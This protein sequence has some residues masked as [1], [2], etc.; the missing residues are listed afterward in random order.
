LNYLYI[1]PLLGFV[2]FLTPCTWNA[3]LILRA[4]VKARGMRELLL[5]VCGRVF[6][7][8][9]V[10]LCLHLFSDLFS[11]TEEILKAIQRGTALVFIVSFP[12][13]KRTGFAPFDLSPQFLF[14]HLSMP[15]GLSLGL[16]VPYCAV[17]FFVLLI[18]YSLTFGD[19]FLFF[20]LYLL[21]NLLPTVVVAV[22]PGT[23]LKNLSRLVPAVP[24]LTGGLLIL[25]AEVVL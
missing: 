16:S 13:M 8:N 5:F 22:F 20:N 18:A 14:P 2:S 10:A 7:F 11:L 3:N 21:S 15:P 23:H 19:S 9:T 1:P 25:L 17:P 24:A 6:F 12:L 4:Y